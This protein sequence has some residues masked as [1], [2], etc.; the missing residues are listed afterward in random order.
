VAAGAVAVAVF[1]I[2]LSAASAWRA[3]PPKAEAG[4][5][6]ARSQ[7]N[8]GAAAFANWVGAAVRAGLALA[9]PRPAGGRRGRAVPVR[10]SVSGTV[11]GV[12]GLVAALTFGASLDQLVDSPV[13]WGWQ[14]D[15]VV[16][17]ANDDIVDVLLADER[18]SGVTLFRSASARLGG[19]AGVQA[20]SATPLR[21]AASWTI[22]SGRMPAGA[23]EIVLGSRLAD[24]LNAGIGDTV[25]AGDD[26]ELRVIGTGVGPAFSSEHLG[27]AALLSDEGV[28]A[29]ADEDTFREALVT[30]AADAD[31]ETVL[32][33]LAGRYEL[34][35]RAPPVAVTNLDELGGLPYAL[36]AVLAAVGVAAVV[37][38]LATTVR[39]RRHELAVL[40]AIGFTPAGVGRAVIVLALTTAAV[41]V[42]VGVPLGFAV[43]RLVWWAVADATGVATE[44]A[45]PWVALGGATAGVGVAAAVAAALPARRAARLHPAALLR[46]ES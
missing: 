1:A 33:D 34:T 3:G 45:V 29:V 28:S 38:A 4:P 44:P 9:R 17:D 46:A 35:V 2:A 37:H 19:H 32:A 16:V 42:V 10:S 21:G 43:G 12:A 40:L 18:L 41:G 7:V 24:R 39:R 11:M 8:D 20:Y 22:L 13:R 15:A 25:T 27:D 14:G 31:R 6:G 30:V 5:S 26:R 23:D 36:G